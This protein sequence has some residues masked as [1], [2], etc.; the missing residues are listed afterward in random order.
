MPLIEMLSLTEPGML[1]R[2]NP[3]RNGG[4]QCLVVINV[5]DLDA[6]IVAKNWSLSTGE[7]WSLPAVVTHAARRTSS[8]KI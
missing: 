3:C 1:S 6:G 2:I 7:L 5:N 4:W 8:R